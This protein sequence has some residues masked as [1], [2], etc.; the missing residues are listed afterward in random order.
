MHLCILLPLHK[1]AA[2]ICINKQRALDLKPHKI[3]GDFSD[4]NKIFNDA[5]IVPSDQRT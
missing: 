4:C 3:C 1:L 5:I 2:L